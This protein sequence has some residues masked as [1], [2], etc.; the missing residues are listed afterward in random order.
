M[1]VLCKHCL[2]TCKKFG[3]ID[4]EDYKS[5]SIEEIQK[6]YRIALQNN[7]EKAKEL[8]KI[9]DYFEWGIE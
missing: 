8:K 5:F 1:K 4:C 9:V 7:P 3:R 2:N 6:E